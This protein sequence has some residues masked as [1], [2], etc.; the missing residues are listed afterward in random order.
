M[1]IAIFSGSDDRFFPFLEDM[2]LSLERALETSK[3]CNSVAVHIF[4]EGLSPCNLSK[5]SHKTIP[6]SNYA[7]QDYYP[8][9]ESTKTPAAFSLAIRPYLPNFTDAD[10]IVWIDADIWFQTRNGIEDL[11]W[12][13]EFGDWS[14]VPEVGPIL[15]YLNAHDAKSSFHRDLTAYY[16]EKAAEKFSRYPI[17]NA[18]LF[19][20][21]RNSPV[22]GLWQNNLNKALL[23]GKGEFLFGMD[24]AALNYTILANNIPFTPLPNTY[25][26]NARLIT[27][28]IDDTLVTNGVPFEKIHTIHLIGVSKWEE[29]RLVHRDSTGRVLGTIRQ[30]MTYGAINSSGSSVDTGQTWHVPTNSP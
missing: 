2:L 17:L 4:D 7:L 16:G 12:S 3:Y 11:L 25:N 5:L 15:S 20:A 22:W 1:K 30:K 13:T 8:A 26:Y 28:I 24:Q 10:I 18:G 9:F 27:S 29:A 19:A 14:G 6:V 21:K 23:T